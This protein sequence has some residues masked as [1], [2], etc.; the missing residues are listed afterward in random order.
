MRFLLISIFSL[1]SFFGFSDEMDEDLITYHPY[2]TPKS[3]NYSE[4][5]LI[6]QCQIMPGYNAA[7]KIDIGK[8]IDAYVIGTYLFYQPIQK[9]LTY[10]HTADNANSNTG[11]YFEMHSNYKS[12]FR[13]AVGFSTNYDDWAYTAEYTRLHFSK[14]KAVDQRSVNTWIHFNT[15]TPG[16]MV[17]S[18]TKAKWSLKL[19]ILDLTIARSF[20]SGTHLILT[21]LFGVKGGELDQS[22][23]TD[24]I[25]ETDESVLFSRDKS[26]SYFIGLLGGIKS[27]FLIFWGF[28][29]F[30][31]VE[32]ALF[33]QDF[34]V[35]NRQNNANN[36]FA[37]FD[38][39]NNSIS[40]INP[41]IKIAAGFEWGTYF[42]NNSAHVSFLAGYDSEIYFNQNLMTSLNE[43]RINS[44]TKEMGNLFFH[45]LV[46]KLVLNF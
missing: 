24:S 26:D 44:R 15:V 42:N 6:D 20:Y 41:S 27:K 14:I 9:G 11:K 12:G 13:V 18:N 37:L 25:R 40:Y 31:D 16:L 43:L 4:G 38:N 34:K 39:S 36:Q 29:F 45:G 28:N 35:K 5:H 8:D 22:F 2:Y 46:G 17:V 7:A 1:I 33:Y 32:G 23:N 10:A 19:D 3:K 30:A 21:P